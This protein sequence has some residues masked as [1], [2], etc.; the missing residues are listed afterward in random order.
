MKENRRERENY[1]WELIQ[2]MIDKEISSAFKLRK[3]QNK[4]PDGQYGQLFI[5]LK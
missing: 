2:D 3:P 5:K 1:S 4:T